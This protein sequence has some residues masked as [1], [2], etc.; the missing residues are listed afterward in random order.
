MCVWV[1]Y[2]GIQHPPTTN[3]NKL[4]ERSSLSLFEWNQLM[5]EKY[6]T[7]QILT[8]KFCIDALSLCE[9]GC[10]CLFAFASLSHSVLPLSYFPLFVSHSCSFF[11]SPS[12]TTLTN[13][14]GEREEQRWDFPLFFSSVCSKIA[15]LQTHLLCHN[16][17][18]MS[19]AVCMKVCM[20][21]SVCA[22]CIWGGYF[23][24]L[25]HLSRSSGNGR[26]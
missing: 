17:S 18:R 10:V 6:Y 12:S 11:N 1:C 25:S 14:S 19:V 26:V 3:T 21:V 5:I 2:G 8:S 15:E 7:K 9:R 24:R 13:A 16:W 4:K 23:S 20:W 22:S